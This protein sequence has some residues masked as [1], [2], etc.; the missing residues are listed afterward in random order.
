[1]TKEEAYILLGAP[2]GCENKIRR[3]EVT[4]DELKSCL[5]PGA[6]RYDTDHV[7]TTPRDKM[8]ELYARIDELERELEA[9]R[10]KKRDAIIEI[11]RAIHKLPET[12]EKT[13]LAEYYIGRMTIPKIAEGIGVS[14]RHC[15]RLKQ[16]GFK[17]FLEVN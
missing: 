14:V 9:E 5:L 3:L 17:M 15:H 7:Q 11:D 13:V 10:I 4:I 1:M 16:N 8:A 6:I 2:R 12:K